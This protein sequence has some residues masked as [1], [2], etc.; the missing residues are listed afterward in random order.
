MTV[1]LGPGSSLRSNPRCLV[2]QMNTQAAQLTKVEVTYPLITQ[3]NNI[4]A[5]QN[6][7]QSNNNVHASGH[8]TIGGNPGGDIYTSPGDPYFHLHHAGID[9]LYWIWQ[10]QDLNTRLNTIAG[11]NARTRRPGTLTELLNLGVNAG[12]V[13]LREL[14]NTMG[15]MGG[16]LCYIYY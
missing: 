6:R 10:L 5:F 14:L 16:E 2:R 3:S 15:G 13:E 8:F 12:D 4:G 7:L 1:H 9:R 11:N